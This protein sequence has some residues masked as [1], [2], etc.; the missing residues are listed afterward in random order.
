[1]LRRGAML[2]VAGCTGLQLLH[3]CTECRLVPSHSHPPTTA[4][5]NQV[6]RLMSPHVLARLITLTGS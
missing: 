2:R 6:L 3:V 5:F 1:M 4:F